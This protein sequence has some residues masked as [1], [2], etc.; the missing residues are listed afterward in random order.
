MRVN[1]GERLP[2]N[3]AVERILA[4]E[5][6]PCGTGTATRRVY[7]LLLIDLRFWLTDQ[8]KDAK[9]IAGGAA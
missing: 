2:D 1:E 5:E 3:C 6:V 9:P 4:T 7:T 8:E